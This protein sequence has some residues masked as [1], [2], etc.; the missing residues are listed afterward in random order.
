MDLIN[1][2]K[3]YF[4][5]IG[6]NYDIRQKSKVIYNFENILILII[7]GFLCDYKNIYTIQQFIERKRKIFY[8]HH[9][10]ENISQVP[11]KNTFYRILDVVDYDKLKSLSSILIYQMPE[12]VRNSL[13]TDKTSFIIDGKWIIG[14]KRNGITAVDVVSLFDTSLGIV[15]DQDNVRKKENEKYAIKR[16]TRS[17]NKGDIVSIDAMGCDSNTLKLLNKKEIIYVVALKDNNKKLHYSS[18]I[19][20]DDEEIK[21][22]GPAFYIKD[23]PYT[24]NGNVITKEYL[25]LDVNNSN[26]KDLNIHN[27]KNCGIRFIVREKK[28]VFNKR[29]KNITTAIRYFVSNCI[30]IKKIAQAIQEH[31]A[32]ESYH[33]LLDTAFREDNTIIANKNVT[34]NL[35]IL[36]KMVLSLLKSNLFYSKGISIEQSMKL[37]NSD[38]NDLLTKMESN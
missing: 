27:Y 1:F 24:Q 10:L 5:R 16:L 25:A 3:I 13:K 20:L 33:W 38:L 34:T 23:T 26:Y 36:R 19:L 15:I 18:N 28:T 17:L 6:E 32:I 12:T 30:N 9:L 31:W 7:I 37:N 14:N 21:N 4:G 2:L 11:S 8:E 35:N 22:K 29:T